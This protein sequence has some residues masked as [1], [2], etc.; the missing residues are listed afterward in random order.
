MTANFASLMSVPVKE[1]P[2]SMTEPA[3][4]SSVDYGLLV[5][6]YELARYNGCTD[7]LPI[8]IAYAGRVYDVTGR[9]P[10]D[11]G[12]NWRRYAGRDCT[13]ELREHPRR[14]ALLVSLPCVGVLED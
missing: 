10:W 6:R 8:L 1:L 2:R 11:D 14:D 5:N 7:E 9:T 13:V 3:M 12:V 4:I